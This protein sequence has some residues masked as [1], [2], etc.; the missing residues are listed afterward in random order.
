M[1]KRGQITIFIIVGL[2]VVGLIV[3]FILFRKDLLPTSTGGNPQ[4]PKDYIDSCIKPKIKEAADILISQGG[5]IKPVL[6]ITIDGQHIAYLCYTSNYYNSCINQ[7][8]ML[9]TS[10][11]NEIKSYIK[12]DL[13]DCFTNLQTELQNKGYNVAL[14]EGDFDVELAPRRVV[15]NIN[16]Q[17]TITKSGGTERFENFKAVLSHPIYDLGIVAQEITSQEA[18][19]CNF[20][21]VG[22]MLLYSDFNIKRFKTGSLSTIYTITHKPT[23]KQFKFAVRGCV[24]PPGF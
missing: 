23:G 4:D 11:K 19:Y 14:S 18:Q 22:F 10:L 12:K 16:R 5:Y 15:L 24:I 1:L 8:P 7:N 13:D 2:L 17:L 3:G 6:N 21:S 9:I 20:E